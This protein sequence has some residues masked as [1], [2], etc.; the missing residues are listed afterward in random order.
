MLRN[1]KNLTK[2]EQYQIIHEYITKIET[3]CIELK[4]ALN[5]NL[6]KENIQYRKCVI[7][8]ANMFPITID[9]TVDLICTSKL[10]KDLK[11]ILLGE[12]NNK[13]KLIAKTKTR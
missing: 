10:S 13:I 9:I 5:Q 8:K 1:F 4:E 2:D 3:E 6:S 11:N 7:T 12:I